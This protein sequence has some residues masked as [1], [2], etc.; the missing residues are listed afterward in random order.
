MLR[1]DRWACFGETTSSGPV[2]G[3]SGG[4]QEASWVVMLTTLRRTSVESGVSIRLRCRGIPMTV[5]FS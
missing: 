1:R 5:R 4:A 3:V 2:E